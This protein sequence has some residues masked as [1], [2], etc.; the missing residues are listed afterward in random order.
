MILGKLNIH[1]Q[2][3][4]VV[5][6]PYVHTQLLQSCPTLFDPMNYSPPGSSVCGILQVRIL[7]WVGM[8]SSRRIFLTQG[9]NTCLL[10]FVQIL[11]P[12]SHIIPYTKINIDQRHKHNRY[13]YKFLRRQMIG[14]EQD[15]QIVSLATSLGNWR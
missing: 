3:D 6:L 2:K 1:M 12:L 9:L 8:P 14:I 10:H 13:N 7:Q 4:K 15:N 11:Y 5:F